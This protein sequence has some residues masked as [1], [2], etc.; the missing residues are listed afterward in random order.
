MFT[1]NRWQTPLIITSTF[2]LLSFFIAWMSHSLI[3]EYREN[4]NT[5]LK[6]TLNTAR[7]IRDNTE[8]ILSNADQILLFLKYEYEHSP[9]T[10][11]ISSLERDGF[12]NLKNYAQVGVIDK[13]GIY[14]KSNIFNFSP[15]DLSG[16]E[17]FQVHKNTNSRNLYI[18]KPIIGKVTGKTTLQLTR[19][20]NSRDGTFDGVI[21]ISIEQGV[22]E[23]DYR[24]INFG[25]NSLIALAGSGW[26]FIAG[27]PAG[28]PT[29][30]APLD[31]APL[32]AA[33]EA[34][35][36]H[37]LVDN[38]LDDKTSRVYSYAKLKNYP[39]IA[40]FGVTKKQALEEYNDTFRTTLVST[41]FIVVSVT[42]LM[43]FVLKYVRS[44]QGELQQAQANERLAKQANQLKTD[45]LAKVTH[46]IRTPMN[47]I[48]GMTEYL[49]QTSLNLE[50]KDCINTILDANMH[51]LNV[52]ND[53]LDLSKIEAGKLELEQI[54]FNLFNLIESTIRILKPLADRKNIQLHYH[55]KGVAQAIIKSDPARIRQ[56]I[57]NLTHNSLK[58][59]T[60]GEVTVGCHVTDLQTGLY[61]VAISIKDTGVGI[62]REYLDKLFDPFSQAT[63][64]T[65]RLYG[66]TGLG[67]TVC[68]Q[69]IDLMQGTIDVTSIEGIGSEFLVRFEAP[70]GSVDR[71][72]REQATSLDALP[73][74]PPLK[75]LIVDDNAINLKVATKVFS[76]LNQ[77][78]TCVDSGAK[79][80]ETLQHDVFDLIFMD[81]EMPVLNGFETTKRI[82][83]G[84]TTPGNQ[85]I[86]II[87]MTAYS[88]N[89]YKQQ[90]LESGMNDF[91]TKPI[92]IQALHGV[93]H[94]Y[95]RGSAKAC[96]LS[97]NDNGPNNTA[98]NEHLPD[99]AAIPPLVAEEAIRRLGFD[100]GL[101]ID[102]C[103][104]FLEKF[105]AEKF[106]IL[107]ID[108]K[109][110][111]GT[112]L[113]FAHTL[114]GVARSIGA[115]RVSHVAQ[116]L[117]ALA[118][119]ENMENL[120]TLLQS[121]QAELQRVEQALEGLI[122]DDFH[123]GS[124]I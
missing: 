65:T 74:L 5:G 47:A 7:M 78:P 105:N 25:Y 56:L 53:L 17:H 113:L 41:T 73:S 32:V 55:Y 118:R 26:A 15:V 46:E 68:K 117:E 122:T 11:N 98:S 54:E 58:F 69:L 123:A 62:A 31:F 21:V 70:I 100:R 92:D 48:K 22:L 91:I 61:R 109:P 36:E 57:F 87:A 95:L 2:V 14:V 103:I 60:I 13:N 24:N 110:Q 45:F 12:I 9:E 40:V 80:I 121:L 112:L 101:Y 52:V 49:M 94:N 10:F 79:A 114:S 30:P 3:L 4:I 64:A 82:R 119:S 23:E 20:L 84:V 44:K 18:S 75:I 29:P 104:D 19:R 71:L 76:L 28:G 96:L 34:A 51:L 108:Q 8:K 16:R 50:Q 86:P 35:P 59:T 6:F 120:D 88:L 90:C 77:Q 81:V 72:G 39:L 66:G 1:S 116:N 42:L 124:H 97:D 63:D 99:M 33:A 83:D 67:L 111:Q 85:D 38:R 37:S 27:E 93:L 43:T 107:F 115:E 89:S 102:I 106:K